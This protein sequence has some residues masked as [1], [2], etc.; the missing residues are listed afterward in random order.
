MQG[1]APEPR[2]TPSS[3]PAALCRDPT[4]KH[5]SVYSEES[6]LCSVF[7]YLQNHY[8]LSHAHPSSRLRTP[9]KSPPKKRFST[10]HAACQALF[11]H[12]A[13]LHPSKYISASSEANKRNRWQ[14]EEVVIF[15]WRGGERGEGCSK[16][17]T[18]SWLFGKAKLGLQALVP[19]WSK[20]P[21]PHSAKP[22][23]LGGLGGSREP[24][25]CTDPHLYKPPPVPP[26]LP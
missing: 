7:G 2:S 5:F 8:H 18:S 21:R 23:S 4:D 9:E 20:T 15:S 19:L 17:L 12:S 26:A 6:F 13:S 22:L 1:P 11:F 10:H 16:E 25:L 14:P 24:E 3:S